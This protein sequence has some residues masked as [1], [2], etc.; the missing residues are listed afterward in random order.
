M[1]IALPL[2]EAALLRTSKFAV[3]VETND[4]LATSLDWGSNRQQVAMTTVQDK[5]ETLMSDSQ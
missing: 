3:S 5:R 2:L 4:A 1:A